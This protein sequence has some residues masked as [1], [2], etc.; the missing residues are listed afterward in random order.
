[1]YASVE[2]RQASLYSSPSV[3]EAE[4]LFGSSLTFFLGI[5]FFSLLHWISGFLN[6]LS[7]LSLC[8]YFGGPFLQYLAEKNDIGNKYFATI[9]V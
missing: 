2:A 4:D 8:C 1:M 3:S 6:L 9:N 7:F 5:P